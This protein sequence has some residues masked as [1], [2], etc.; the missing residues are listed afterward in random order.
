MVKL[1]AT[2]YVG[3][4]RI[5]QDL[6][7]AVFGDGVLEDRVIAPSAVIVPGQEVVTCEIR[8]DGDGV[9]SGLEGFIDRLVEVQIDLH[10]VSGGIHHRGQGVQVACFGM[11]VDVEDV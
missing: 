8:N 2:N 1:K 10:D 9:L 4:I 11:D 6:V 5:D 3:G 7:V